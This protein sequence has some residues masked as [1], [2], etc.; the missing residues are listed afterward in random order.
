MMSLSGAKGITVEIEFHYIRR[1][2]GFLAANSKSET[3]K[4][5][6]E[7]S[8]F[9]VPEFD[10]QDAPVAFRMFN[11][12]GK[13][14]RETRWLN[15]AHW[16]VTDSSPPANGERMEL[17][18]RDYDLMYGDLVKGSDNISHGTAIHGFVD[19]DQKWAKV[20]S[21]DAEAAYAT[22]TKH[23]AENTAVIGGRFAYRVLEPSLELSVQALAKQPSCSVY[24]KHAPTQSVENKRWYHRYGL[25]LNEHGTAVEYLI[26]AANLNGP[27][28][29]DTRFEDFEILIPEAFSETLVEPASRKIVEDG[30]SLADQYMSKFDLKSRVAYTVLRDEISRDRRLIVDTPVAI[31][32]FTA[33]GNVL[34]EAK[35]RDRQVKDLILSYID[36]D[37]KVTGERLAA[38]RSPQNDLSVTNPIRLTPR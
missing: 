25:S 18:I 15:G 6:R 5:V 37:L 17:D 9:K 31:E 32:K 26:S 12:D 13:V 24:I 16:H 7:T 8:K 1:I 14:M 29:R 34:R 23:F 35:I 11:D 33:F 19:A 2:V 28:A 22:A 30:L 10:D 3:T 38:M 36:V 27:V 4:K 20:V 21:D